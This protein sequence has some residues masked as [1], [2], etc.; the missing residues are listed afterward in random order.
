[1][2]SSAR[3]MVPRPSGRPLRKEGCPTSLCWCE[4]TSHQH[5]EVGQPSFLKGR[6]DGRGTIPLAEDFIAHVGVCDRLVFGRWMGLYGD[7]VVRH[8]VDHLVQLVQI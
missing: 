5:K 8:P 7:D 3:G 6:P 1:M 2:K 4:D